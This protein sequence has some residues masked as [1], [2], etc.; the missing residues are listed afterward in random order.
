LKEEMIKVAVTGGIGSGKS[1]VCKVFHHLGIPIFNAD[2]EAK[3]LMDTDR[4]IKQGLSEMFGST[5]YRSDGFID[6]KKLA[7]I[8]FHDQLALQKVNQLIH[9]AVYESFQTWAD[10]QKSEYIIQEAAIVFENDHQ[11]RYDQIITVTA[12]F[13]LRIARC[14]QRDQSNR[15]SILERMHNQFS[16]EYKAERSAFIIVNDE[17]Q[18]IVPQILEI[19]K[20]LMNYGKIW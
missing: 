12:P 18:L 4:S 20:E 3:R 7:G 8:I 6:R 11:H 19:H 1:V 15:E 17:K 5:L 2:E 14:I 10:L 16:D 9:P 13:E